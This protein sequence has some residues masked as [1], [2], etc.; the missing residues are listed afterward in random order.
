MSRDLNKEVETL[1]ET[2]MRC[3]K[4]NEIAEKLF[5]NLM[6]SIIWLHL[7]VDREQKART[8]EERR[9]IIHEF[10]RAR[11]AVEEGMRYVFEGA[12]RGASKSTESVQQRHL[13]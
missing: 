9:R 11:K 7:L 5:T 4:E 2:V 13:S 10:K 1:R 8:L 12:D 3:V 6:L